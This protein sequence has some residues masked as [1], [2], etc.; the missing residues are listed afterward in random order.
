MKTNH[1]ITIAP[2]F[3]GLALLA[4]LAV[5][6][7]RADFPST[8]SGLNPI[9]WWRF[10]EPATSPPLEIITN[11]SPLGSVA[12]GFCVGGPLLA[13]P[14][15]M[16]N[17]IQFLNPGDGTGSVPTKADVPWNAALNPKPPFSVE[18]WTKPTTIP[19]DSTGNCALENFDP[20]WGSGGS[21]AGWLFYL[22]STTKWQF[23]LGARSGYAGIITATNGNA[24]L[25]VWQH[26]VATWDGTT[27]LLYVNGVLAGGGSAPFSSWVD[28]G[29]SFLRFGGTPL[30]GTGAEANFI[31]ALSN[32]GNRGYDGCL[33]MVG[34]YTNI[35]SPATIAAH[36]SAGTNAS[37]TAA[38][39]V[40]TVM[41][42]NPV[43]FW[44]M[45]DAPVATP[46]GPF[47]VAV[48]SGSLGTAANATNY[49]GCL[50][51]QPGPGYAG[52]TGG[53]SVFFDGDTGYS[54]INDVGSIG[55]NTGLHFDN[56]P[57]TIT[58]SAWIKPTEQDFFRNIISHGWDVNAGDYAETFLRIS[59]GI[60]GAF[61]GDGNYYEVGASDGTNFYD[62]VL[63]PIPPGDIGNWVFITGTFDGAHWNLYRNGQL[64]GSIA[65]NTGSSGGWDFDGGTFDV[66]A[67]DVTNWWTIGSR[68]TDLNFLGQEM[69]FGGWISEPAI[70]NYAL[71]S[72]QISN[73]YSV[74][75]VPPILTASL[76][77]PGTVPKGNTVNF[78][79]WAD[80]GPTLSYLWFT[81]GVS[82]GDTATNYAFNALSAGTYT[83][84]VKVSN[85]YGTNTPSVTFPVVFFPA[86]I[87]TQPIPESRVAGEPFTFSV[88]A[89]S[90][91][92]PLTYYW[93]LGSTAVQSGASSSYSA[94]ASL[95]N[96]GSYSV[97]VSNFDLAFGGQTVTSTP[98]ALVVK[99]AT[100]YAGTIFSNG[101]V[102]YYRLDET[103]GT[104]AFDYA[105][106][107]NGTYFNTTL[108]VPGFSSLDPDTAVMFSGLNSYVG[109]ID[110]TKINFTGHT[111]F[112]LEAWV[113][114]SVAQNDQATIIAKGIGNNGT[115]ETEQFG[116]DVLSGNYRFFT[117]SSK[118]G[119]YQVTAT[120]GPN[121]TW[122]HI[123]GVYDDLGT[124][125][126]YLYVNGALQ[127]SRGTLAGGLNNTQ[128]PVSIGSKRTGNDPNY[129]GTFVGTIDEVAIYNKA[130]TINQISNDFA[131]AYGT[132]TKPFIIT[133]P[134]S[135]T[136]YVGL[137][138]TLTVSAAGSSPVSYQWYQNG[139]PLTDTAEFLGSAT[140]KLVIG[141]PTNGTLTTLADTGNY[142]CTITNLIGSTNTA[143]AH[144]QILPVPTNSPDVPGA[145]LHLTFDGNLND[146]TG[147]GNNGTGMY[148]YNTAVNTNNS[149]ASN[150]ITAVTNLVA[151]AAN[152]GINPNFC[153]TD[154]IGGASGALHY[155][156]MAIQLPSSTSIGTNDYY[157]NL[158]VRPDLQFGSNSFTVSYWVRLPFTY[159]G[160]D[161][162]FF[163]DT[164]TSTGGN[165]FVFA[166]AYANGTASI[167]AN[168][169]DFG[170]AWA[171]S[172]YGNGAGERVYGSINGFGEINDGHYHN[173][174][175]I[176]NR[177]TG[178]VTTYLD[179]NVA[180]SVLQAG[181]K[182]N[183]AGDINVSTPAT[184]GQ[185]P[186][187]QYGEAGA[188]D[189]DDL[190]VWKRVLTPL[191]V[192]AIYSAGANGLSFTSPVF[193]TIARGPGSQITLSWP[194][195][196][197]QSS[198]VLNGTFT[199]VP[200]A[201][202]PYVFT[203]GPGSLFYRVKQ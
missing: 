140:P 31:S 64:A 40:A 42:L 136:N 152:S 16:G 162:P 84:S 155:S 4:M 115:T 47:P 87:T 161:L 14:G 168:S 74:A 149:Y 97:I 177:S 1:L 98:A 78:T 13:Q 63:V 164:P 169:A 176:V 107:Y 179:G 19:T 24:V 148:V 199:N 145:V 94:I 187:G 61:A 62:S 143:V 202:S 195:G 23:R 8:M 104:T 39:Y 201:V 43:G 38:S 95:G 35:L 77:N 26:I 57:N 128:S 72:V 66:G 182:L 15:I 9:G 50:T 17:C 85:S 92:P 89:S 130:L 22:S 116:L 53:G 171:F 172:I 188:F 109:N 154:G 153:Y 175:H 29:Q 60:G 67:V 119:I 142:T 45:Q 190:G 125:N 117:Y 170:G 183:D 20:N 139:T 101:P 194:A 88:D 21:R 11:A 126:M 18:F 181:T 192:G 49:W 56:N 82:T 127:G 76:V 110:G 51:G 138:V 41:A 198:A 93:R 33:E 200:G 160:G 166:P 196:T 28:N 81:N 102:A 114:A 134:A 106:G 54:Q 158:G 178:I 151:P 197:L 118:S 100:G 36:Y 103:T 203:P 137:P 80:G 5:S 129:D 193:L 111:N 185:D 7:A 2:R 120:V 121:G 156:T 79:V 150:S 167:A 32:N 10:N 27:A 146:V 58:L 99:P 3:A 173:L 180:V 73:L 59:P 124:T 71:S 65:P 131:G 186:T 55:S 86:A 75:Q 132:T 34:I 68:G 163:T 133:Q 37:T 25:N 44:P 144:V 90:S 46:P 113:N 70:F 174:V 184:V 189:I 122:Q 112:S 12:N 165:G 191:E 108:G 30:T 141:S 135:T 123:V 69:S 96:A 83:V 91:S 159:T 52:L 105:G 157:V 6:P 48:N 147:R